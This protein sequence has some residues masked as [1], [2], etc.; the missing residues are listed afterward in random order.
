MTEE[1]KDR[2]IDLVNARELKTLKQELSDMNEVDIAELLGD[3]PPE[4][5]LVIFRLLPKDLSSEVFACLEIE[6]QQHIINSIS[7]RELVRI[8]EDLAIDDAVDMVEE[9]P[10]SVVKRI[11]KNATPETRTLINQY[12]QYPDN[13]AGSIMTA[14]YVALRPSMTVE[15][16][17]AYIRA[18][19][20]DKETIYTC[21]VINESRKLEGVV[22]LKDLLMHPYETVVRDIMDDDVICALTTDD[23][24]AVALDFSKYDLLALPVVDRERRLVGIVT[25][26]DIV[27]VMEQ[28]ATED[29]EKMA[30]M[31][32]SEKSYLKTGV[33][34]L[35]KNRIVWLL[36]LMVSSTISGMILNHYETTFAALPLLVSF[37]PTLMDTGGNSGSQASTMVIRGLAVDDL[38]L[39]DLGRVIWKE[40]RVGTL[41]GALLASI[42]FVV[43]SIQFPG[44]TGV[45]AVVSISMFITVVLAKTLGATLP[46]LAKR[47]KLDPALMASPMLTTIVDACSMV[48]YFSLASHMLRIVG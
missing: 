23:Q 41:C 14:E 36:V 12:L 20:V 21:Y 35:A 40:L 32:P 4:R 27:D 42:N 33:L 13:S 47:L 38:S 34:T 48:I 15:E 17:F 22:T 31:V 8:I 45:I 1:S 24:E 19:G 6:E 2:L 39:N 26:D 3:L 44:N 37:I 18:N 28:E 11:L 43:R 16:S 46:M 7:D 25:V 5:V 30:A 10:A 29:F 9:L